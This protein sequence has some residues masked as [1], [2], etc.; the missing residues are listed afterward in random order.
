MQPKEILSRLRQIDTW[1]TLRQTL[2]RPDGSELLTGLNPSQ[3]SLFLAAIADETPATLVFI[4]HGPHQAQSFAADLTTFLGRE[5]VAFFPEKELLPHEETLDPEVI[6]ARVAALGRLARKERLVLVTSWPALRRLVVPPAVFARYA[7]NCRVGDR[8]DLG[9]LAEQLA[10][11]GYERV[12]MIESQGQFAMRG[13]IMDVFPFHERDPIRIEFFDDEIE[14][15]RT[16]GVASQRSLDRLDAVTIW[17]AREG[18]WDLDGNPAGLAKIREAVAR[19]AG[20]LAAIGKSREGEKLKARFG[21]LIERLEQGSYFPGAD[22]FLP[23]LARLEP[24]FSYFAAARIILDEPVRGQEYLGTVEM[25]EAKILSDLL[26][27]G[28]VLPEEQAL[29]M[30]G[31]DLVARTMAAQ[32]LCLSLL[33]KTIKGHSPRH[34]HTFPA[35][36][37]SS[38]HGNL[39]GLCADLRRWRHAGFSVV[40]VVG[41]EE[42]GE[43]L[44]EFLGDQGLDS[45]WAERAQAGLSPGNLV[46]LQGDLSGGAEFPQLK[47]VIVTEAEIYG[48]QKRR[49][50]A[51]FTQEGAKI[52]AFSDLSVGDY[53]VHLNHGIGQYMGL[54]TLEIGGVHRDYLLVQYAGD[55]RLFVPTDQVNLLQRYIGVEDAA[56]RLNRLGGADWQRAKTRVK[57]S[58]R[59]MADGLLRLYADRET[60]KGHAFGPD[61]VWQR[62]FEESFLYE[63]TPDQLRAIE[64]I[65]RDMERPEPMD[66]LL[67]GDVGYGKT[68]VAVRAAFKAVMDGKQVALLVPTTILAQQHFQTFSERFAGYPVTIKALSRFQS[69]REQSEVI[70]GLEEGRVELVIGT[71]R[72]LSQDVRFKNL[73]LLIVDEEQRFGV[74]HKERLKELRKEVDV[75]TLTATPIP[76]TLHMALVGIRD[77]SIIETPPEDRYPIRTYVMEF[78]EEVVREAIVRELDR[79][80]QVYFVYNRVETIERMAAFLQ[81]LVPEARLTVAHGQMPE[82]MLERVMIEFLEGEADVLICT[83]IIESGLD[84][85]NVNTLIVYDADHFGLAQLYQL[86]GRVGRSNRLAHA[87]FMYRREK[88]ISEAAEKRLAAI[89]EFTDLGSGFKIALRDLEIRGAGN[90]LGPEQ[91]GFIASVGFELYC[92]LLEE[93]IR[94]AKGQVQPETPDPTIDLKVDAFLPDSFIA[95]ARQKVEL[96]KKIA[97]IRETKEADDVYE[98]IEDRFGDLPLPVRNLLAVAKLKALSKQTGVSQISMERGE[99]AIRFLAGLSISETKALDIVRRFR[100]QV[101]VATGKLPIIRVKVAGIEDDAMLRVLAEVVACV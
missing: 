43:R 89:R 99:V 10:G 47:L 67:C 17:P 2:V 70:K 84:I 20:K 36:S 92:R 93:A 31:A 96:Y 16:F 8:A 86:R 46:F 59:E 7:V 39:E 49:R 33:A 54:Q 83:T 73:G 64:E 3:K 88:V 12:E 30:S 79:N 41:T 74:A 53:V 72:L 63:E 77:M 51:R 81:T 29:Y 32:P 57:E 4:T 1:P 56:P 65:K 62:E 44:R 6:G 61:T 21:E 94:E 82:D 27:R 91:H 55:D 15:I 35:V 26:E 97:A 14:S 76:R 13:G 95:D 75:L 22:Q 28:L 25:E 11:M 69:P 66:R 19:Q 52:T 45:I 24:V 87:Y 48:K 50:Q 68:E 5:R 78:N 98:E 18:L 101:R 9:G 85:G 90:L 40:I 80:G 37:P 71:H 34:I 23:F 100:G 58:V 60:V 38:Y 42:R